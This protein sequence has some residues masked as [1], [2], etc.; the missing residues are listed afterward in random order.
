MVLYW[1]DECIKELYAMRHLIKEGT[2]QVEKVFQS[3]WASR[4]RWLKGVSQ[5][6]AESEGKGLVPDS[7]TSTLS[8]FVGGSLA[9]KLMRPPTPQ[10]REQG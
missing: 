7:A 6:Y 4:E 10:R 2:E 3:A 5:E 9:E 1:L 8:I